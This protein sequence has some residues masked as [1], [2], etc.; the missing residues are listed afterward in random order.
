MIKSIVVSIYWLLVFFVMLTIG[1]VIDDSIVSAYV[2]API[3]GVAIASLSF[4]GYVCLIIPLME[5]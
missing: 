1:Q 2:L 5:K 4:Y 3:S